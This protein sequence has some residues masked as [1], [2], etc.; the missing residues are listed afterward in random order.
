MAIPLPDEFVPHVEARKRNQ[1]RHVRQQYGNGIIQD[2][3]DRVNAVRAIW[4]LSFRALSF[5]QANHLADFLESCKGVEE[6]LWQPPDED[7]PIAFTVESIER[8]YGRSL[9]STISATFEQQF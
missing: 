9:H 7:E 3:R 2:R 1:I 6:I 8:Q 4:E 5:C